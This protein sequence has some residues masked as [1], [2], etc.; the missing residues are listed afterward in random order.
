MGN[1]YNFISKC[2]IFESLHGLYCAKIH[3][4]NKSTT[5][6]TILPFMDYI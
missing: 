4:V 6:H 5:S 1:S 3:F 2:G